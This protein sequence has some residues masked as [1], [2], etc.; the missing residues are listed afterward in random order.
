MYKD[1]A[2]FLKESPEWVE[3]WLNAPVKAKYTQNPL[4]VPELVAYV[5]Q[6]LDL[7]GLKKCLVINNT[8]RNTVISVLNQRNKLLVRKYWDIVAERKKISDK[9]NEAYNRNDDF[10]STEKIY[11]K[12]LELCDKKEQAFAD[13]VEIERFILL[14]GF[15]SENEAEKINRHIMCYKDGFDPYEVGWTEDNE[16][17]YTWDNE[18]PLEYWDDEDPDA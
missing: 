7:P 11:K 16:I 1:I 5:F 14:H 18:D 8:W 17:Y 13:Q 9:L 12:Y 6:Y 10:I 2:D 15:A 3:N 4:L